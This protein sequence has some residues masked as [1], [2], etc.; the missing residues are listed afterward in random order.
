MITNTTLSTATGNIDTISGAVQDILDA[1]VADDTAF[2]TVSGR[3]DTIGGDLV[4]TN[5]TLS[6]TIYKT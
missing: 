1:E 3:V 2:N 4:I 6:D 5:T